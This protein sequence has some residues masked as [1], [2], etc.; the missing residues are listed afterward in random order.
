MFVDQNTQIGLD[1][2]RYPRGD[3]RLLLPAPSDTYVQTTVASG[4]GIDPNGV[5]DST[6]A[7]QAKIDA[8]VGGTLYVPEGTYK[9]TGAGLTLPSRTKLV[10]DGWDSIFHYTGTGACVTVS[11]QK[12]VT[13]E[14]GRIDLSAAGVGA[15]GLHI[16]G[17][18]MGTWD[19]LRVDGVAAV[20]SMVTQGLRG[21]VVE[22]SATGGTNFGAYLCRFNNLRMREGYFNVGLD[23]LQ[24]SGDTTAH[25]TQIV[26]DG[27]WLLGCNYGMR[28]RK[29]EGAWVNDTV[30]EMSGAGSGLGQNGI[31]IDD[32]CAN[33]R[34]QPGEIGLYGGYGINVGSTNSKGPIHLMSESEN[35]AGGTLGYLNPTA[36]IGRTSRKRLKVTGSADGFQNYYAEL[37]S[38]FTFAQAVALIAR[39]G[40]VEDTILEYGDSAG[41]TIRGSTNSGK[42]ITL[43]GKVTAPGFVNGIM[44]TNGEETWPRSGINTTAFPISTQRL[45]LTY[46]TARKTETITQVG[47]AVGGTPAAA[48]PTLCRIGIYTIAANGDG[49]LVASI[50]N[51]TTLFASGGTTYTRTLTASL[52]KVRGQR[53]AFGLLVVSG[54]TLP[55][56]YGNSA[57]AQGFPNAA[58][59]SAA[60][61]LAQTLGS[62]TDLPLSFLDSNL[63]NTNAGPILATLLP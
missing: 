12:Y 15:V 34:L 41:T 35:G 27:G 53:Y 29:I 39:G 37:V 55:T 5:D 8:A 56:F 58:G 50:A 2:N 7:M 14:S 31:D 17:C 23:V 57:L 21:I 20:A 40:G 26:T 38:N 59:T 60:P 45:Q 42:L 47:I 16:K 63:T 6:A 54:A 18:W 51:D 4:S 61:K 44:L 36:Q 46:F 22:T 43:D 30:F 1:G 52:S 33:V 32:A 48:T 24:T 13:W 3:A 11:Q 10:F 9:I 62:Q 19:S 25:P 28:M 49:T